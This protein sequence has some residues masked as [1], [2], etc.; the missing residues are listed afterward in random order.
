MQAWLRARLYKCGCV[1][2]E[3]LSAVILSQGGVFAVIAGKSGVS[4]GCEYSY[5]GVLL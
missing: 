3:G 2:R 5:G 1:R 4:G